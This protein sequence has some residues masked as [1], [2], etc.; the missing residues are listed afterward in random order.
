MRISRPQAVELAILLHF[1]L[2]IAPGERQVVTWL[3]TVCGRYQAVHIHSERAVSDSCWSRGRQN[4]A[5]IR[6]ANGSAK[7]VC[8]LLIIAGINLFHNPTVDTGIWA[9]DEVNI[10]VLNSSVQ[11]SERCCETR[12]MCKMQSRQRSIVNYEFE[13]AAFR[14]ACIRRKDVFSGIGRSRY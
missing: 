13:E 7:S 10:C 14:S 12:S 3:V 11:N 8:G 1:C 9:S 6:L 2:P 4:H 5:K